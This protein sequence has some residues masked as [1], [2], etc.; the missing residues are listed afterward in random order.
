MVRATS[1][2]LADGRLTIDQGDIIALIDERPDL[3]YI[4]GQNQ[5]SF[6]I[7]TFPRNI[8]ELIKHKH[9]DISRPINESVRHTGH[10]S[11]L[12]ASWG[13]PT[14]LDPAYLGDDGRLSTV[15]LRSNYL[16]ICS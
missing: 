16:I 13:N 5:R 2:Y 15:E 7:G 8:V 1:S 11:V 14:F 10:G 6:D 9:P 4:K 12:G 3:R